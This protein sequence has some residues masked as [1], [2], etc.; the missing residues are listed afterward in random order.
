MS[1][2]A[3]KVLGIIGCGNIG[4]A[5]LTG[6]LEAR[7]IPPSHVRITNRRKERSEDLASR[8]GVQVSDSNSSCAAEADVLLVAIKP[9]VCTTILKEIAESARGKLIVSVAAGVRT[10]VMEAHLGERARVIRTMPNTPAVI[11]QS[12]TAIAPGQHAKPED[13]EIAH[14]IFKAV[15]RTVAVDESQ[16]DAVTGLSGSG[17]AYIFLIAEAFADA[18]VKVGLSREIATDLAIQTI[19]GAARLLQETNEHPGR[20]KDQV[21]SPGGTTIT[22]LYAL[23]AGGLRTTIINA[24]EA[25][26]K[27]SKALG[28]E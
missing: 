14:T 24:V 11:K 7:V 2:L 15:G 20:L 22:G 1:L 9:Q 18:G 19:Q 25:A 3:G 26:T 23:E 12:A 5:L 28:E 8:F 21:T 13:L 27:R 10:E 17:P 6:M 4:R 16:L